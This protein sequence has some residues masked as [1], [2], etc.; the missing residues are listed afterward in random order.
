M[1]ASG[2]V[3][4]KKNMKLSTPME[5]FLCIQYILTSLHLK[6]HGC[7]E[8]GRGREGVNIY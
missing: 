4:H 5:V 1:F 2:M 6:H 8:E 7:M 3:V